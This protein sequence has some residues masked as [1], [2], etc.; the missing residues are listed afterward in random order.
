MENKVMPKIRIASVQAEMVFLEL[1]RCTEKCVSL[2]REAGEHGCDLIVFPESYL[3]GYPDWW[4]FYRLGAEGRMFDRE[5]FLNSI[6][7]ESPYM[8]QICDACREASINAVLGINETEPG[9]IGT[10]YNTHV[11]IG[12]DGHI[13]GKHQKYVPTVGERLTQAP[14]TTGYA[15]SFETDFGVVSSLI[16]GENSNPLG[17]YAAATRYPVVHAAS[18][19]S[20]FGLDMDMHRINRMATASAAYMLKAFVVNSVTRISG[21]YIE[22]MSHQQQIRDFLTAEKARMM[23]ATVMDPFGRIV[24]CGDGDPSDLLMCEVD[25]KDVIVPHVFQDFAGHY[26]RPEL[27][28]PL[29][30]RKPQA[31]GRS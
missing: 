6:S 17:L 27:F 4:E 9:V 23:G 8:A 20:H 26:Q 12:R 29:F 25:L 13:A 28:A 5:L 18:W 15:N 24:A 10:M 22:R 30:E 1:E 21:E 7:L 2:I 14:G 11:Y 3:P 19:P 31:D 16:C